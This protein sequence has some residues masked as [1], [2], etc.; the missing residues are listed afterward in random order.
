MF[1]QLCVYTNRVF[2]FYP[3]SQYI[4]I[5]RCLQYVLEGQEQEEEENTYANVGYVEGKLYSLR[6]VLAPTQQTRHINPLLCQCWASV[7]DGEPILTQYRVNVGYVESKLSR[8][9]WVYSSYKGAIFLLFH[10]KF[11]SY[12]CTKISTLIRMYTFFVVF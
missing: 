3:Q 11:D 10:L 8:L 1:H 4:L 5:H 6:I 12:F 2:Y 9:L 7:V